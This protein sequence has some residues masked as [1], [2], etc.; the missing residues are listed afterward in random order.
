MPLALDFT[1]TFV[2]GVTLPVATTLLARPPFSTL[3]SFDGSILVPPRVAARTPPAFKGPRTVAPLPHIFSLRRCFL[4]LVPLPF[5]T[6]PVR[7]AK[8]RLGAIAPS[9]LSTRTYLGLF[10]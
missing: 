10:L 5:T 6:P 3:A 7:T 1:S 2:M 8:W 9:L 4:P